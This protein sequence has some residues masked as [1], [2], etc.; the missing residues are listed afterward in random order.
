MAKKNNK[1]KTLWFIWLVL[2]L[3]VFI[4]AIILI[5]RLILN[6]PKD[7]N[8]LPLVEEEINLIVKDEKKKWKKQTKIDIFKTTYINDQNEVMV[9]SKNEEKVIA[10]GTKNEYTFNLKNT[11]KYNLS[12]VVTLKPSLTINQKI[13]EFNNF[14]IKARLKNSEN[15]YILGSENEWRPIEELNTITESNTLKIK[16][17]AYYTLEW[18]W[19]GEEN[20]INDT[21]LGLDATKKTIE[22]KINVTTISSKSANNSIEKE[23]SYLGITKFIPWVIIIIFI[24]SIILYISKRKKDRGEDNEK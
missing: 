12:Y 3:L 19:D 21:Q 9:D 8:T 24:I 1:K 23:K 2:L 20:N 11:G 5:S 10:P 15:K 7:Y 22:L 17:Y 18:K 4:T 6:A 13:T 14:P 16:N